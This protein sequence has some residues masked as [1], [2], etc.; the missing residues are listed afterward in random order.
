MCVCVSTFI[1]FVT[2][3]CKYLL[4]IFLSNSL[5]FPVF[6]SSSHHIG[7]MKNM[8]TSEIIEFNSVFLNRKLDGFSMDYK[9]NATKW[10]CD[11]C[12]RCRKEI[13]KTNIVLVNVI[14]T[15]WVNW[16]KLIGGW[17]KKPKLFYQKTPVLLNRIN[18]TILWC[19][20]CSVCCYCCFYCYIDFCCLSLLHPKFDKNTMKSTFKLRP[21]GDKFDRY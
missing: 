16:K 19:V 10:C 12:L 6:L 15:K 14:N 4:V 7:V 21:H 1:S 18:S 13:W 3:S 11:E 20:L 2:V 8:I 17:T 5:S 9:W